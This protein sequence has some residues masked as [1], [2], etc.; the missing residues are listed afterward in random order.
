MGLLSSWAVM[1]YSHH[2][3]VFS[4]AKTVKGSSMKTFTDYA[5]LGDDVVIWDQEV[6]IEYRRLLSLLGIGVSEAKSFEAVGLAEFAKAYY[7]IG[8]DLKPISPDLLIWSNLEGP[9]N[10][11]AL[12]K[13][14]I[15]KNYLSMSAGP[16]LK[17][18]F[19][20]LPMTKLATLLGL[21]GC[22]EIF[23]QQKWEPEG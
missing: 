18:A 5:I 4:A 7:C 22:G 14:L 1:A 3:L 13:M 9:M 23:H 12:A 20:R 11:V 8:E 15:G 2:V 10:L 21:Y 16:W 19:P 17:K 6:A